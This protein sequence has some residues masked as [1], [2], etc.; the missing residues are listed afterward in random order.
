MQ[1]LVVIAFFSHQSRKAQFPLASNSKPQFVIK[2]ATKDQV[3]SFG[4]NE[5][6]F[7]SDTAL[8]L[9]PE[10]RFTYNSYNSSSACK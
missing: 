4:S 10:Q 3:C 7:I 5:T 8:K 1:F 2:G 9:T 6:I